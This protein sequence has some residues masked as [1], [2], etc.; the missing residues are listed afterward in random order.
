MGRIVSSA[1]LL[2]ALLLSGGQASSIV[3]AQIAEPQQAPSVPRR[4]K[5]PKSI[6]YSLL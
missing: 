4:L 1:A 6:R 5:Q 2:I 3:R